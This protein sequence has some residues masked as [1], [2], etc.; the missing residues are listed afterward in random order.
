MDAHFSRHRSVK[1]K[2]RLK[3]KQQQNGHHSFTDFETKSLTSNIFIGT[4][5]T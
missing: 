2:K 5:T 1:Q 3:K 4:V